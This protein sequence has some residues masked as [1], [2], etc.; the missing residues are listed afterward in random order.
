MV[1]STFHFSALKTSRTLLGITIFM[2][3]FA[4]SFFFLF[5]LVPL[6]GRNFKSVEESNSA[7]QSSFSRKRGGY[8]SLES[9]M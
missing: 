1:C 8:Y 2:N 7:M 9:R 4:F 6:A 5:S 3:K